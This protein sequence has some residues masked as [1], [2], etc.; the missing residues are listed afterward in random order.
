MTDFDICIRLFIACVLGGIVGIERERA[1]RAAGLRTHILV[2]MGSALIMMTSL[3]LF[4]IYEGRS[5][6]DPA[7]LSAQVISGIGFLGAGTIIRSGATIKGLTTAASL[8]V[9]A[10]IGLAVGCGFWKAA[11]VTTGLS[12]V[13]LYLIARLIRRLFPNETEV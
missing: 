3:Y 7:R 8:W 6:L 4:D 12:L 1:R 2:C 10:A 11:L 5:T 13:G 9:V